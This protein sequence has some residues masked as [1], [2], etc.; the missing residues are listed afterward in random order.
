MWMLEHRFFG[1]SQPSTEYSNDLLRLL[2]VDQAVED[3]RQ[4]IEQNSRFYNIR[5]GRWI[6]FGVGYSGKCSLS[7][8]IVDF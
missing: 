5:S 7:C 1:T 6:V 3:A 2:T 8:K 4:F